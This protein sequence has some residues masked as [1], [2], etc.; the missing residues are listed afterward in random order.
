MS[1][2]GKFFIT[3]VACY[4]GGFVIKMF[5][6]LQSERTNIDDYECEGQ[7]SKLQCT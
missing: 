6:Y 3:L 4:I 1:V 5:V 7:N 2:Q